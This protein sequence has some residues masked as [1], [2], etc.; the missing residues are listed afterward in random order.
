M[1]FLLTMGPHK[2]V[3][4]LQMVNNN[5]NAW[6]RLSNPEDGLT[7]VFNVMLVPTVVGKV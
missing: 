5:R 4:T 1:Y 3:I 7:A 2:E 6:K